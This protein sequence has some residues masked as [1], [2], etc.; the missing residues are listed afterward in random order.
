MRV[1][2]VLLMRKKIVSVIF[3]LHLENH[4]GTSVV[5]CNSRG[6]LKKSIVLNLEEAFLALICKNCQNI[7]VQV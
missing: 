4:G 5:G 7:T 6:F 3:Q 2:I 1:A